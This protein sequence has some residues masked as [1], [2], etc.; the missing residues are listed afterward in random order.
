M[1]VVLNGSEKVSPL[2]LWGPLGEG[3]ILNYQIHGGMANLDGHVLCR[4]KNVRG[5]C[6]NA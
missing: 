3:F 2:L 4:K 5:T 6:I 1:D